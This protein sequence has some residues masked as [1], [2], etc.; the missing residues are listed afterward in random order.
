MTST[1]VNSATAD[2]TAG[3]PLYSEAKRLYLGP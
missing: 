2:W 3:S 1:R